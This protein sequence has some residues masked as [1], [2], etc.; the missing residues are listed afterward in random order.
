MGVTEKGREEGGGEREKERERE[1]SVSVI[2]KHNGQWTCTCM[3]TNTTIH[4]ATSVDKT[5]IN[6][7]YQNYINISSEAKVS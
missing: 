1:G 4:T 6:F 2:C 3:Y 7:A 5:A